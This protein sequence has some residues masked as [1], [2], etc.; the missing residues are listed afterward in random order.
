MSWPACLPEDP[1]TISWQ[2]GL[3]VSQ[4]QPQRP[5]GAS[6]TTQAPQAQMHSTLPFRVASIGHYFIG[7]EGWGGGGAASRRASRLDL[8]CASGIAA[9]VLWEGMAGREAA[10]CP[11]LRWQDVLG[12]WRWSGPSLSTD[13]TGCSQGVWA[14]GES[15]VSGS[16]W[17]VGGGGGAGWCHRSCCSHQCSALPTGVISLWPE[18]T[19][20]GQRGFQEGTVEEGR[21]GCWT[22]RWQLRSPPFWNIT[23]LSLPGV[24][25]ILQL[26][27]P[28]YCGCG[29]RRSGSD[30]LS[31]QL[32]RPWLGP[33][34]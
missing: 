3:S 22:H 29:P 11:G 24:T 7:G 17:A 1:G 18:M 16:N 23:S 4:L 9:R 13:S 20:P 5:L 27:A 28:A 19:W 30:Q 25:H 8:E 12:A 21:R 26:S 2:C 31:H 32:S 33:V 34:S 14:G 10:G 6:L 15:A